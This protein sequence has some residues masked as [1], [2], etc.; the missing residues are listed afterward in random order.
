MKYV[1]VDRAASMMGS[2]DAAL[3]VLKVASGSLQGECDRLRQAIQ[4]NDAGTCFKILHT[5]KGSIQIYG[6]DHMINV[7]MGNEQRKTEAV[8]PALMA[9]LFHFLNDLQSMV[10]EIK[11]CV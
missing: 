9:D 7:V 5:L 8:T 11:T 2:R 1:D 10:E 4:D 3:R 6:T